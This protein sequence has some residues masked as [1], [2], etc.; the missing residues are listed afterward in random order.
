MLKFSLSLI[1]WL[2]FFRLKEHPFGILYFHRVLEKPDPFC[3][4]DWTRDQFDKLVATLSQQFNILPLSEALALRKKG[5]LAVK[6][7]CLSFDDGYQDNAT[8][9][10]PILEKYG[11]KGCFFVATQGIE[12]GYLWNDE[13]AF[14]LNQGFNEKSNSSS[15]IYDS[16]QYDLSTVDLRAKAFLDLVGKIK[17][18]PNKERDIALASIKTQLFV[19]EENLVD[20][21]PR[22]MMTTEQLKALQIKGHDIGAHT[23]S[24]SIL[25][26]QS[27]SVAKEE[28][29]RSVSFLNEMLD[30]PV[31]T[32]A[33]PNGWFGRDFLEKHESM[34]KELGIEYGVATNDGGVTSNTRATAI[35][36]FMPYRKRLD[37]F[38]LSAMK[39]MGER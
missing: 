35:P 8:I 30:K 28:M 24:H 37:Q 16:I 25:S 31:T 2:H 18:L 4:D 39:I 10:A 20:E 14:Y 36:R 19:D 5:A 34:L 38:C 11:V 29:S 1:A 17:V 9:A 15:I 33:Y 13:L 6:T 22:C 21:P 27:E 26:Y 7:L 23:H 12:R 3:P 32:F